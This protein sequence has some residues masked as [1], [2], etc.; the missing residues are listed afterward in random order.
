[1][2]KATTDSQIMNKQGIKN[3][4]DTD[5]ARRGMDAKTKFNYIPRSRKALEALEIL[6]K[7]KIESQVTEKD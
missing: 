1:L 4:N 5:N 7:E 3:G 2:F 6:R